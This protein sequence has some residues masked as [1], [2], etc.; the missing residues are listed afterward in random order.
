MRTERK[1]RR[2]QGAG[3][4]LASSTQSLGFFRSRRKR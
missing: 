1:K 4:R 2:W 3:I